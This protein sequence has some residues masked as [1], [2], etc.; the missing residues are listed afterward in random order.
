MNNEKM[1]LKEAIKNLQILET[2]FKLTYD[3]LPHKY[4]SSSDEKIRALQIAIEAL[5]IVI[6]IDALQERAEPS[7]WMT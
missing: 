1:S 4:K 2:N 5:Q 3:N 7:D 6:A